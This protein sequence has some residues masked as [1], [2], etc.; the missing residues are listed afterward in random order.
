MDES[1]EPSTANVPL[2]LTED[3]AQAAPAKKLTA[4]ERAEARRRRI[5]EK[6][7]DRLSVVDG[8]KKIEELQTPEKAG[9]IVDATNHAEETPDANVN[10]DGIVSATATESKVEDP[11]TASHEE[12]ENSGNDQKE[13]KGESGASASAGTSKGSARLAQMR[14]RRY[15]KTAAAKAEPSTDEP[16]AS[17]QNNDDSTSDD[18]KEETP[19]NETPK[20]D[21]ATSTA[22]SE[23]EKDRKYLGV[24]KMRRKML[25]EKKASEEAQATKLSS[26]KS[27]AASASSSKSSALTKEKKKKAV[28]LLRPIL[29]ELITIIFLFL[30][31]FDVGV[32]NHV[33]VHQEVPT[34]HDNFAIQDNGV[35]AMKL[36]V[37]ESSS[38]NPNIITQDLTEDTFDSIEDEFNDAKPV[39]ASSSSKEPNIDPVFGVDFDELTKGDSIFLLLVRA[40]VS[41]HRLL[42]YLFFILPM[43]FFST[44]FALPKSLIVN[45]PVLFLASVI[46]RYLGKHVLGG[47]IPDLDKMLEAEITDGDGMKAKESVV[48]GIANTDFASMGTNFVKNFA[49]TNFPKAVLVYTIFSDARSD[50]FVVF[51]GFF[52]GLVIPSD[53]LGWYGA[54]TVTSVSEE[55]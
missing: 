42:T 8:T 55:L 45:P 21:T 20:S 43:S 31:G 48:E 44:L 34:I 32:Q 24:V 30:A 39:G 2:V 5:L 19:K 18:K 35:G 50:M 14:R 13:V 47:S 11:P 51:C 38:Q 22:T 26:S 17:T 53:V 46:I 29:V 33:V 37:G 9:V 49:K 7:K 23:N 16:S 3:S 4:R 25:A 54:T 40:A 1:K 41:V 28:I 15:K 52:L 6:S 27:S 12:T 10:A 36:I